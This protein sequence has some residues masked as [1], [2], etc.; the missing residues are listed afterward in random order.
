V[1]ANG[2]DLRIGSRTFG[3]KISVRGALPRNLRPAI[4]EAVELVRQKW[5]PEVVKYDQAGNNDESKD[6]SW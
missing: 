5:S 3:D 2:I 1:A 4:A 6:N